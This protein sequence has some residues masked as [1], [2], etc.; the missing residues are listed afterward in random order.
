MS[1]VNIE[2]VSLS[3]ERV[4]KNHPNYRILHTLQLLVTAK[5]QETNEN[6]SNT[7]DN[8]MLTSKAAFKSILK[9]LLDNEIF[10]L[11]ADSLQV[12]PGE[13]SSTEENDIDKAFFKI[14]YNTCDNQLEFDY[15]LVPWET[16]LVRFTF[17]SKKMIDLSTVE[18]MN[19]QDR[20]R[21]P[22]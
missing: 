2:K 17:L 4:E 20:I 14:T 5:I 19:I 3:H 8:E 21:L 9:I 15:F 18:K 10:G 1:A 16:C 13:P 7:L 11:E 22:W 6:Q 12:I